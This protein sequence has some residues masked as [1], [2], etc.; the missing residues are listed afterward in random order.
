MGIGRLSLTLVDLLVCE[1]FVRPK[2]ECSHGEV[3]ESL[4]NIL[5]YNKNKLH[6]ILNKGFSSST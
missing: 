6:L 1:Q 2:P 4:E 5:N 3:M